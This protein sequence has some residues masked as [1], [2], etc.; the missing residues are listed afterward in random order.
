M[1]APPDARTGRSFGAYAVEFFSAPKVK[2]V[3]RG[4]KGVYQQQ[5][6]IE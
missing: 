2:K 5:L 6:K 1:N 3:D 4:D